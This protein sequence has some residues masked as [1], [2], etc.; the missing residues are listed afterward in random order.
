M[1]ALLDS[2][3]FQVSHDVCEGN[4]LPQSVAGLTTDGRWLGQLV[5]GTRRRNF[6]GVNWSFGNSPKPTVTV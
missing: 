6:R 3:C 4:E 1:W 2:A 5:H